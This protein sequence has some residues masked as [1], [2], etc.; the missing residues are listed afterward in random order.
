VRRTLA[1]ASFAAKKIWRVKLLAGSDQLEHKKTTT[2]KVIPVAPRAGTVGPHLPSPD[3][4]LSVSGANI[5][6]LFSSY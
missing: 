5:W 2:T 1:R 3:M 4:D 6:G